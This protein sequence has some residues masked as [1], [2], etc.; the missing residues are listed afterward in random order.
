MG[1]KW[2]AQGLNHHS[3]QSLELGEAAEGWALHQL[4]QTKV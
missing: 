1:K 4:G 2:S 3:L